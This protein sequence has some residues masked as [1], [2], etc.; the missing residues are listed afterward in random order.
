L[1]LISGFG[2]DTGG[3]LFCFDGDQLDQLD[4]LSTTGLNAFDGHLA[5]LLRT[6]TDE[7]A[8]G[9][10]LIYD[11]HGLQRYHRIDSLVDAHGTPA[12]EGITSSGW[13][14]FKRGSHGSMTSTAQAALCIE[15][16]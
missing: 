15:S 1:L 13:R 16:G 14:S 4:D 10:L 6:G 2:D 8:P 9:E 5:R 3:G 11:M 7:E 12:E